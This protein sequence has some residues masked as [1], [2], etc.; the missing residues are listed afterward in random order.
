MLSDMGVIMCRALPC[1][2]LQVSCRAFL[3]GLFLQGPSETEL[4]LEIY[5][6]PWEKVH[7]LGFVSR[8]WSILRSSGN[9]RWYLREIGYWGHVLGRNLAPVC[10]FT[11][12]LLS[13]FSLWHMLLPPHLPTG[14]EAT[15][16]WWTE[17][18]KTVSQINLPIL[19]CFSLVFG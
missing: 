11:L 12:P 5:S 2:L 13:T 19:T 3:V 17:L 16:L 10:L 9:F 6:L 18:S 7:V 8:W 4:R 14:S 1:S 15:K